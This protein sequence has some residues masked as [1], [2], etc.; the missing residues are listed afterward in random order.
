MEEALAKEVQ[1][2]HHLGHSLGLLMVDLDHFKQVNDRQGHEAGDMVLR[3][4][5]KIFMRQIRAGDIVCRFGGEEFTI[6]LPDATAETVGRRAEQIRAAAKEARF[7]F[8]FRTLDPVTLSIGVALYPADGANPEELLQAAD[9]AMY[10]AKQ[11]GRDRV[12]V[13]QSARD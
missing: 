6:L 2:A 8:G 1:K 9:T 3:E 5:G 4:M 7:P 13:A 12:C 11:E 10:R